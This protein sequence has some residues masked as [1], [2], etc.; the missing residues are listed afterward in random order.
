MDRESIGLAEEINWLENMLALQ[1]K[2]I[3][4]LKVSNLF[5]ETLFDGIQEQ[6]IV[7]DGDFVMQDANRV[8]L[9]HNGLEKSDIWGMR[10][11]EIIH[12]SDLPCVYGTALCPLEEARKTGQRVEVS[13]ICE[14]DDGERRE[15]I[16]IMY[17][18]SAEDRKSGYFMEI[19][20]DVTE[21]RNLIR[22]LKASEN[23]L[24]AILDTA[25]DAI[26]SINDDHKVV[27]FNNAAERIFR[28]S[29]KEVLGEKFNILFP[30]QY[31]RNYS[32]VRKFL[33]E[34]MPKLKGQTLSLTAVRRN[35]ENFPIKLGLS[36]LEMEEGVTLTAIIRDV[37]R[38]KQ[39]EK[40]LLQSERLA[41]VGQ[42]VAHV[43]HEIKNP[44]MI[45]GGFSHQI[46][47]SL[48]SDHKANHKLDMIFDE[49]NRLE[50]LVSNLGDFT[51]EYKLVKRQ[52]DINSLIKDVLKI[53]SETYSSERYNFTAELS[54]DL[55]AI[56][57]DPDRMKQVFLNII[58]NGIEA[59]ADGGVVSVSTYRQ[60]DCIEIRIGD[61]GSGIS[62][63]DLD[64]IF[65]PFYTTRA[66][67]S[68]LGLSISY[69][70][71]EAH[72]GEIYAVSMPGEGT[73]FVIR[74][75]AG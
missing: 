31:S 18:L 3:A 9:E 10:C 39:L 74:L 57:S 45:I 44:L 70:I 71:V 59:M 69:K 22:Q 1:E 42:T 7:I 38:Q 20:R 67:G 6:I 53:M 72:K 4:R 37:S 25:T 52:S 24:K 66:R 21:F 54:S 5:L 12:G 32:S 33:D 36:Y 26:V 64:H 49:L 43:A 56:E 14:Q 61:E 30:P 28:Y 8:F 65:E 29:R 73:T 50:R 16:R 27:L 60:A 75:P 15:F 46:K 63:A 58:S 19:S 17:P 40:K 51:K 2:E 48:L 62:E 68:G 55:G 47:R 11:H 13:H 23:R 34:E 41:A 35:G